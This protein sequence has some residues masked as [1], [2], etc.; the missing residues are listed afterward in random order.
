MVYQNG[1]QSTMSWPDEVGIISLELYIPNYYVDQAEL[2][3]FDGGDKFKGKY[4]V[5]LGQKQ[6]GFVGDNEDVNSLCL[7]AVSRLMKRQGYSTKD[8]GRLEVGTESILD[9]SKGVKT[10]LMQLFEDNTDLEGIDT[11]N[12]CYGGTS[13][14]FNAVQ[15]VESSNW[16]GRFA[17]VVAADIAIYS[18]GNARCTGG[19]GAIAM[20]VGP[21]AALVLDR[22]LRGTHMKHVY[23]FYKPKLDS[24]YPE[25]DG[26]LSI[27]CYLS[28]LDICYE[29]YRAKFN[30]QRS[31]GQVGD[32]SEEEFSLDNFDA[33]MFHTPFCKIVQKSLGRL[34][35]SEYINKGPA[36]K[37]NPN[38]ITLKGSY[39]NRNLEKALLEISKPLF[40]AKTVPTLRIAQRVGN[41]YT[42][43]LY[44]CLVSFLTS[45]SCSELCNNKLAM[46]SYGSG[47]AAT[48]YSIT[49][50][51]DV[52]KISK[53]LSS[54][55]SVD[56]VLDTRIKYTPQ[57]FVDVLKQREETHNRADFTPQHSA[58]SLQ[59]DT[60]YLVRVDEKY[61]R[62][63]D[64]H[65]FEK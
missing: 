34:V 58:E 19:A 22:G 54:L 27:E 24:E 29:R 5:G 49:T 31:K 35:L 52:S 1:Y 44:G 21:N 13:A 11:I 26:P 10:V 6:M 46:F 14:L 65:Q 47:M 17:L 7:T 51:S 45:R 60:Y 43:S 38:D 12:A 9:R 8:F 59:N 39:H 20:V 2:E 57:K 64:C 4:T 23:D 42:P 32:L 40:E 3:L 25:V 53:L 36:S 61:R 15:W 50:T 30:L 41:M 18:V 33:I 55:T 48:M 56:S 28:A 37:A 62:T 16:D 63:Y